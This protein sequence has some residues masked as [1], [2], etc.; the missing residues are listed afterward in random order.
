MSYAASWGVTCWDTRPCCM[1]MLRPSG[2]HACIALNET[3]QDGVCPFAKAKRE[4][5]SYH[6]LRIRQEREQ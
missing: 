1:K 5:L 3:Y 6:T 2:L 4:D